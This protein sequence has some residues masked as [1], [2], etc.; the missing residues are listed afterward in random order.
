[1]S[2]LT[3]SNISA[4]H[5]GTEALISN[6]HLDPSKQQVVRNCLSHYS[7]PHTFCDA[8]KWIVF[9][10]TNLFK[11]RNSEWN[12]T[13]KMIQDHAMEIA[14]QKGLVQRNPQNSLERYIEKKMKGFVSTYVDRSLDLC[15][16]AENQ[17]APLSEGLQQSLQTTDLFYLIHMAKNKIDPIRLRALHQ[18]NQL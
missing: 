18:S 2:I 6:M 13:K 3:Q 5:P 11:G 17:Q 10:I 9:R 7:M 1:M 15:L 14:F 4:L 12:I 16:L 8:M